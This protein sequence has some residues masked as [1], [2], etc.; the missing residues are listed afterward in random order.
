MGWSSL[1]SAKPE[2]MCLFFLDP[3]TSAGV[4][5]LPVLILTGNTARQKVLGIKRAVMQA[6]EWDGKE[7]PWTG[8]RHPNSNALCVW[9]GDLG[10]KL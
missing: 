3:S 9:L 2:E 7:R 6:V 5:S 10:H 1:G 4:Q 8:N